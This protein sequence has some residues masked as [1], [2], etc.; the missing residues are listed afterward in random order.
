MQSFATAIVNDHYSCY[1]DRDRESGYP[2]DPEQ[3]KQHGKEATCHS[4]SPGV[5]SAPSH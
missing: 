4:S 5:S 3:A 1:C 2:P